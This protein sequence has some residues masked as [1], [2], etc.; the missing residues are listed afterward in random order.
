MVVA[1]IVFP[2]VRQRATFLITA[3]GLLTAFFF[4]VELAGTAEK[5]LFYNMVALDHLALFFKGFLIL[6][7]LL[8]LLAAPRSR[9]LSNVHL[10]EFYALLLG[11]TL[12]MLLLASSAD[13]LMLYLSLEMVSL[14]SYI[15]VGYLRNDRLSNEAS[16]KYI[17]F[18]AVSTGSMLYG[19]TL[20]FG[21][22]G[23]TKMSAI[24]EA[25]AAGAAGG[26][27]GMALLVATALILAGFGF[28]TAA[29]PTST[30]APP[31]LSLR[32]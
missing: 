3:A 19:I 12:G 23:S 20:L 16:L 21:L 28:K 29:V 4:T 9:E 26:E 25:L 7:S 15:M 10:G 13:M 5:L 8:V 14:T 24:R 17:L 22:T 27:N 31:H 32:F 30:R 6:T 11:V 1:D 2:K 18:G